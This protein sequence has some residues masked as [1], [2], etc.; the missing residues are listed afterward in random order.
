MTDTSGVPA[1]APFPVPPFSVPPV[2]EAPRGVF[3]IPEGTDAPVAPTVE[4]AE[5]ERDGQISRDD[6]VAGLKAEFAMARPENRAA[7]KAELDRVAG[8]RVGLETAIAP[9]AGETA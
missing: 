3:S 1:A 2:A 9:V 4:V 5:F 7:I 6:Y 8:L